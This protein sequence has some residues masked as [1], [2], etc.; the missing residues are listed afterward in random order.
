MISALAVCL[1]ISAASAERVAPAAVTQAASTVRLAD[2][3]VA[4]TFPEPVG[5]AHPGDVLAWAGWG[6]LR[7]PTA[8]IPGFDPRT[9]AQAPINTD[10]G[11]LRLKFLLASRSDRALPNGSVKLRYRFDL[12]EPQVQEALSAIARLKFFVAKQTAGAVSVEPD[13]EWFSEDTRDL[14]WERIYGDGTLSFRESEVRTNGGVYDAEDRRYRGPYHAVI[15]L[16]PIPTAANQVG[17]SWNAPEYVLSVPGDTAEA[18]PFEP[19]LGALTM[20]IVDRYVPT[21]ARTT[22]SLAAK[23]LAQ[24]VPNAVRTNGSFDPTPVVRTPEIS[25]R[26]TEDND[27]GAVLEYLEQSSVRAGRI[28]IPLPEGGKVPSGTPN[29]EFWMRQRSADPIALFVNGRAITIGTDR[30]VPGT[31][32]P[33]SVPFPRDGVWH[34]VVVPIPSET[35]SSLEFGPSPTARA[36]GKITFGAIAASLDDFSWTSELPSPAPAVT[37][38]ATPFDGTVDARTLALA[39]ATTLEEGQWVRLLGDRD[40]QIAMNAIER[41]PKPLTGNM[42]AAI[43]AATK[44]IDPHVAAVAVRRIAEEPDANAELEFRNLMSYGLT[45]LARIESA[46]ALSASKDP[47]AAGYIVA[48]LGDRRANVRLGGLAALTKMSG[49]KVGILRMAYINQV[50]PA[51][52]VRVT[53]FADTNS[54]YEMRKLLW[55]AVNEPWDAVRA[56]SAYKLSQS[57]VAEFQRQGFDG[58]QD[59]SVAVRRW[60]VKSWNAA[61]KPA[62]RP[63]YQRAVVNLDSDVRALALDGLAALGP[64]TVAEVENLLRDDTEPVQ[65]ALI[66]AAKAERLALPAATVQRLQA[67]E[68]PRVRTA[69]AELKGTNR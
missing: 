59:D 9:L 48:L 68:N 7:V 5:L 56:I 18:T 12:E 43:L 33:A 13:L 27:R 54:D 39:E 69:A 16:T 45:D 64:V 28:A 3:D 30:V 31:E 20:A 58:L 23:A 21:D 65:L 17:T 55:S 2:R 38:T 60:L 46:N 24:F 50:D 6:P 19:R 34:K 4:I 62:Y 37:P 61:P 14:P 15:H 36:R 8:S 53:Q 41:A 11:K 1:A 47:F 10:A 63:A 44:S 67:S 25:L 49:E 26:V 32:A 29:L 57:T 42:R 51:I 52:K 66:R 35:V 40:P 22:P